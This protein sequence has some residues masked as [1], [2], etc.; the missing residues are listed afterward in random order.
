MPLPDNK[1]IL[2]VDDDHDMVELIKAVLRTKGY[3]LLGA[4]DGEEGLKITQTEKPDLVIVDL[5]MPKMSG[6]EFCKRVRADETISATPLLVVSSL[7]V[8]TD[9]SDAFWAT[10][11][12]SD[13]FLPKPFDPLN[14]LG[15]VE[16]LLRKNEYVSAGA[17]PQPAN[18][19]APPPKVP[20]IRPPTAE[21]ADRESR[22]T[23][24]APNKPDEVVRMFVESWNSQSFSRE[25][26][27]LGEEMLGG[28]SREEYVQRR[29]QLFIDEDG[30]TT[31]HRV[32]DT[33]VSYHGKLANVACLR[34]DM[35]NGTPRRKDERYVLRQDG[36]RWK[37][38]SVRSRPISVS[39]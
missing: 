20:P 8:G 11:L 2:V 39:L 35:V 21:I 30:E 26:D 10:G 36:Q 25:Y 27:A 12:G 23:A 15:R 33:V 5:R 17:Q 37:I 3:N 9:K 4:Y 13:D 31:K 29:M 22:R 32:L 14:L 16:Y 34:E 6:L 38:V 28:V 7:T 1:K 24:G 18:S 19:P